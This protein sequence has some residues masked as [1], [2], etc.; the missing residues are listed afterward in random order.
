[1]PDAVLQQPHGPSRIDLQVQD[2]LGDRAPDVCL[3]G[4]MGHRLGPELLED[5]FAPRADVQLVE[6]RALQHVLWPSA[7]EVI[8]DRHLVTLCEEQ[9]GHVRAYK[10]GAPGNEDPHAS[11]GIR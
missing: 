11:V 8:H 10:P 1:V 9:P 7:R 5:L 2:G 6:G 4:L 3:R